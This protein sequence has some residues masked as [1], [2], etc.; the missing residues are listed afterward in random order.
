MEVGVG[1][2][3]NWLRECFEH[4]E[5]APPQ[6]GVLLRIRCSWG[7]RGGSNDVHGGDGDV[8]EGVGLGRSF[9]RD[10]ASNSYLVDPMDVDVDG[11]AGDGPSLGDVLGEV[12]QAGV[13]E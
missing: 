13:A 3:C 12:L 2:P 11:G 10:N 9:H 8:D 1:G 5:Q 4:V 6:R 7:H